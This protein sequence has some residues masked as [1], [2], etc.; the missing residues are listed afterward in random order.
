MVQMNE[1]HCPAEGRDIPSPRVE[2]IPG[3]EDAPDVSCP[4]LQCY[5]LPE[6]GDEHSDIPLEQMSFEDTIGAPLAGFEF[7]Y[8]F[9]QEFGD[10]FDAELIA[11]GNDRWTFSDDPERSNFFVLT[12][13]GQKLA[14]EQ[15]LVDC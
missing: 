14:R 2:H 12:P 3:A 15:G 1:H 7:Q 11:G 4:C 6:I 5:I 8:E 13:A 9:P 10:A